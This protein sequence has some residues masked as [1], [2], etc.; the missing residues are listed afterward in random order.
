MEHLTQPQL[1]AT[2]CGTTGHLP[3]SHAMLLHDTQALD[4]LNREVFKVMV[5]VYLSGLHTHVFSVKLK[6]KWSS[7]DAVYVVSCILI[8]YNNMYNVISRQFGHS[9]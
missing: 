9:A 5:N 3:E 2:Y 4:A 7:I 8:M 6:N 1:D